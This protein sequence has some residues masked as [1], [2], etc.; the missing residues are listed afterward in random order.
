MCRLPT[1]AL[2]LGVLISSPIETS[3]TPSAKFQT[4]L[5]DNG[6][7]T[8]HPSPKVDQV[9]EYLG[10]PYAQPPLKDLRFAA[11]Q[12]YENKGPYNAIDFVSTL[13]AICVT[14]QLNDIR[15]SEYARTRPY[16][17]WIDGTQRLSPN[18]RRPIYV[19]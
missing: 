19:P 12:Q 18:C 13:R 17:L 1:L 8:G 14:S 11:P 16:Y 2:W 4:V 15:A 9:W 5:T 6:L 3:A 7:I 10:I